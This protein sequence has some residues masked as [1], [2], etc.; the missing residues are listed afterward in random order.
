MAVTFGKPIVCPVIVGRDWH[1]AALRRCVDDVRAGAGQVLLVPGEAGVGKSRLVGELRTLCQREGWLV[2]EGGCFEHARSLPYGPLLDLLRGYAVARTPEELTA[3]LGS[4]ARDVAA[5]LPELASRL[6]AMPPEPPLGPEQAKRH[7][8]DALAQV[9]VDLAARAPLLVVVEDLHWA[10]VASVEFLAWLAPRLP[11]RPILLA[12]TYRGDEIGSAPRHLLAQLDRAR[13]ASE[14][15]LEPLSAA[16]VADMLSATFQLVRPVRADFLTALYGLTEGN[17]FFVEESLKSLVMAGEIFYEDGR[18][19]RKAVDEL[20]IP[21]SVQDAVRRRSKHLSATGR[22]LLAVAAV[23]GQRFAFALLAD[24]TALPEAVL[25][26]A[27]KELVAAQL[28]VEVS[29]ERFGFRHALTRQAIYGELLARERRTRHRQV[30]DAIERLYGRT[31]EEVL[32]DLAYHTYAAEDWER[33]L[34]FAVR[35]GERSLALY[36][37]RAAVDH[38]SRAL[39]AAAHLGRDPALSVYRGRGQAFEI[40]GDLPAA[41]SDYEAALRAARAAS[42]WREEWHVLLDLG[43]LWS[44]EDYAQTG[45]YYRQAHEL[46]TR[47]GDR[48]SVAHSLNRLGNWHLNVDEPHEA[49]R[50]HERALAIFTADG[51]TRGI[52]ETEDLL[53]MA[54]LLSNE[55]ARG[56]QACARAIPIW[57]ELGDRRMLSSTLTTRAVSG[58]VYQTEAMRAIAADRAGDLSAAEE[59]LRLARDIQWRAGEAFALITLA[60]CLGPRGE[61]GRALEMLVEGQ[62]V[63]EEI[64]HRQWMAGNNWALAHVYLDLG[65]LDAAREAVERSWTLACQLDSAHWRGAAAGCLASVCIAQGDL[66]R[67]AAVLDAALPPGTP[68]RSYGRLEALRGRI[69]LDLA[70][71]DASAALAACVDQG[72]LAP[73]D[74]GDMPRLRLLAGLALEALDRRDEARAALEAALVVARAQGWRM[75]HWRIGARLAALYREAGRQEQADRH[76][77]EARALIDAVAASV[78]DESLRRGFLASALAALPSPPARPAVRP[79]TPAFGGLTAREREVARLVAAGK[80][81]RAI[82]AELVLSERTVESH[83]TNILGKLGFTSRTQIA[84]WALAASLATS[85]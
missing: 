3:S 66:Q 22:D 28:I 85:G 26:P 6:P 38:F 39:V 15:P 80:S 72:A 37:P 21:R 50:D 13:V 41:R 27:L 62:V 46:A 12:L 73:L 9:F 65:A 78:P 64:G 70:R 4:S 17:P 1:L 34:D 8:F 2:L 77:A 33:A 43:L 5:L 58:L 76:A 47:E 55:P 75:L 56:A 36:A 57:R 30:A 49:L 71:G 81:N 84:T 10:D 83:V 29:A 60:A 35:A 40:L 19:D 63:A 23:A 52:A 7:R 51:L 45:E 74:Q 59:A 68:P 31:S 24:V 69:E 48:E 14:L 67:A 61:L 16:E 25:L 42:L 18:W 44:G 53:G 32:A 82:A 11:S 54:G 20:H 79:E